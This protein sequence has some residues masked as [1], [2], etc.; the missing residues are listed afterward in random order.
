MIIRLKAYSVYLFFVFT[1]IGLVYNVSITHAQKRPEDLKTAG[2]FIKVIK[3]YRYLDPDSAT[4]F[5]KAGLKK[6]LRNKD[7]SGYAGLLHQYGMILDN[8]AMYRDSRQCYLEAEAIYR[9]NKNQKGLASTLIRLGVVE[10]RKANY[11]RSLAYFMEALALSTKNGDKLGILEARVAISENYFSLNDFKSCLEN[12]VIAEKIDRQ[13]PTS[14]FSLNMYISYGYLYMSLK[15]YDKAIDYI[16]TGLSK[17]NKIEY[18]GSKV[19]LLKQLGTAYFE[20]GEV[21]RAV[22]TLKLALSLS[23]KIKN[24]MRQM[25]VLQELADVYE[26][27]QPDTAIKYLNE[28]LKIA[29]SH[30]V[31]L[32][33]TY[34]LN[35]LGTLFKKKGDFQKALALVERS[36]QISEDVYYRDMNKQILSLERAYEL[37]KSKAQLNQLKVEA[38]EEASFKNFIIAIAVAITVLFIITLVYYSRSRHL[39]KLLRQANYKLEGSNLQKDRFFSILAHDIRSPLASSVTVLKFI[40]NKRLKE[41]VQEVMVNKL[42]LHC[43]SS[44]GVL[45][46][47]LRWGQ[48]QIKGVQLSITEFNPKNNIIANMALLSAAAD[49]KNINVTFEVPDNLLVR[50]DSDHFDFLVRNLLANAIKF[51]PENG[52]ISLGAQM[53]REGFLDFKVSDNGVGIS[54]DRIDTLFKLAAVSTK[55]TSEEVGTSLGLLICKEFVD[56][57]NGTLA[58]ESELGKGTTFTFSLP[59]SLN[60]FNAS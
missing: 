58:V 49:N 48:M 13:L 45:D 36:Y 6:A 42:I 40:A 46:K 18:N 28:A 37:E 19:S 55:G 9:R 16:N 38:N 22:K 34:I 17:S 15:Q 59:G 26:K 60:G 33:E 7:E 14:S 27:D 41:D 4:L 50:A 20:K 21:D 31:Y 56:A 25:T 29:G 10:K 11:D 5:V 57:N 1:L 54:K 8:A 47:L 2:E 51:T 12:L 24:V 3:H 44:L 30:K 35:K 52:H 39:N 23:R 43:E 32:Q 53:M